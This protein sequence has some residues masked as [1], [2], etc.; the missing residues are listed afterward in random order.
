MKIPGHQLTRQRA[1]ALPGITGTARVDRRTS[2]LIARLKPGDIAIVDHQDMDRATAQ[3]LV[4]AGVAAVLNAAPMISGRYPNLGPDVLIQAGIPVFDT[5]GGEVVSRVKDGTRLRVHDG[6]VFDGADSV[7]VGRLVDREV[8]DRRA[9]VGPQRPALPARELHPQQ[10][11]VPAPRAGPAAAR[12]GRAAHRHRPRRS[13]GRGRGAWARLGG[14]ARRH[15]AL[16]PGAGPGP[17]RRRRRR[18]RPPRSRLQAPHRGGQRRRRRAPLGRRAEEGQG[19][20]R[21]RRTRR[22]VGRDRAL[23]THR[24][25]PAAVRDRRHHRGRGADPRGRR[26][27]QPDRRAW[28]CTRRSTS[29]STGDAP[30]SP[31]PTSPGSRSARGSSTRLRFRGCTTARCDRGT[32]WPLTI[33][34]L[35]ALAAAI[36]V[37]PVGQEWA[38]AATPVVTDAVTTLIERVQGLF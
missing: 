29:S 33:A 30:D 11:R 4:D 2:H 15:Q 18:R 19:R 8:V 28:A 35:L 37:T 34:G 24:G 23:R 9:G 31:A 1:A 25:A 3:A 13:A 21:P 14:R 20:H 22:A 36:G 5:F 32:C 17:D 38:D 12:P 16:H 26:P 10:H 27:G 7:A 6:E